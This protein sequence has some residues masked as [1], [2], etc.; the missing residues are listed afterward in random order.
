ML[1]GLFAVAALAMAGCSGTG[2]FDIQQTEPFRV[3]LE[4]EPQTVVVS[5]DDSEAK[6]VVIDTCND[7]CGDDGPEQ[8]TVKV[9]VTPQHAAACVIKVIIK[10]KSTGEVLEER[11]VSAGSGSS[12]SASA[13]ATGNASGNTSATMT[14]SAASSGDTNVVIQNIVVNVKGKDNIVVLT[15]AIQGSAD[16]DISAASA[17]GNADAD[18]SIGDDDGTSATGTTT[19]SSSYTTTG[20]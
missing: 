10:D 12:V 13:T 3:Q 20:P 9:Q 16:V 11:E 1:A 2:N 5:E 17:T 7:P 18:A 19:T 15:Q 8:V 6:E 14:T 4:G